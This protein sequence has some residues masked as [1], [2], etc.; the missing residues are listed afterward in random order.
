MLVLP[1][2]SAVLEGSLRTHVGAVL[3]REMAGAFRSF[4]A[5]KFLFRGWMKPAPA[6]RRGPDRRTSIWSRGVLCLSDQALKLF[7]GD[8][9]SVEDTNA[10]EAALLAESVDRR[11][12]Q[13]EACGNF[14]NGQQPS[15]NFLC[16]IFPHHRR[17]MSR[18]IRWN[19]CHAM[20][21]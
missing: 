3:H 2:L 17:T 8:A 7:G 5:S 10:G 15:A 6:R 12:A 13:A 18:D 11:S 21:N 9:N 14:T 16:S 4:G 1:K 19:L 20:E